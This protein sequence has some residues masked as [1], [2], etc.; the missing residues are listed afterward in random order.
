MQVPAE[1][2]A[3]RER[4]TVS[5]QKRVAFYREGHYNKKAN[6]IH[7]VEKAGKKREDRRVFFPIL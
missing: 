5:G 1:N 6:G 7:W 3:K 4:K 2:K